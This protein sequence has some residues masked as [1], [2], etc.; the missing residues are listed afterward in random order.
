MSFAPDHRVQDAKLIP[1]SEV[2][3]RL[4]I[5]RLVHQAG[6][7]IGP[8]PLCGGK[9]RFGINLR[10]NAFLCRKCDLRGGDQLALTMGVLNMPFPDA[11]DF[12]CGAAQAEIDPAE[13]QR[14][15]ARAAAAEKKQAESAERYRRWAINDARTI[16]GKSR[17][18]REGVVGT[19]LAA[20]GISQAMLPEIPDVLNFIAK[21]PYVK[22]ID[23]ALTTV[24]TGPCM[25]AKVVNPAGELVAVHQTWISSEPPH[26]KA[27][28]TYNGTEMPAKMVR[29]SKKGNA[30][31]LHTPDRFDTLIMGEGIETTLTA[32][33]ADPVPGSAYWAGVD[34]GNMAGIMKKVEGKKASG[35]P[36]MNDSTAFVPPPWVKRLI[37]IQDGDSAA[38]PTRAK[39]MSGLRRAMAVV[40]GLTG[41]IVHAGKGVD[42][43]DVLNEAIRDD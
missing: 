41:Q 33:V 13:M 22:K 7:L 18:G 8:C 29:G 40:P 43:N 39:L 23:G 15:R 31:R 14:R 42:L 25:I 27:K 9:D 24:H 12:L 35:I 38:K 11:L 2:V 4:G 10:T 3:T 32:M 16:W 34:L 1:M 37:Y 5:A 26:G 36:D 21:H 20:R 6:E 30:I 28:I 19:Y 17:S